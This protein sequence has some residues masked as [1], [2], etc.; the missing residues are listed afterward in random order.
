MNKTNYAEYYDSVIERERND[1]IERCRHLRP[2]RYVIKKRD[3]SGTEYTGLIKSTK[4]LAYWASV[5]DWK[6]RCRWCKR[7]IDHYGLCLDC[8]KRITAEERCIE[9][10]DKIVQAVAFTCATCLNKDIHVGNPHGY[11]EG[12]GRNFHR[13]N[14]NDNT[15]KINEGA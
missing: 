7:G 11:N 6:H 1:L 3:Y 4:D 15:A 2:K 13:D 5:P 10:F 14:Q 12:G 9:C 8:E